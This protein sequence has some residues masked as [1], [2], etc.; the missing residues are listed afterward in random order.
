MTA[1]DVVPTDGLL[2]AGGFQMLHGLVQCGAVPQAPPHALDGAVEAVRNDSG[3]VVDWRLTA[4]A[5]AEQRIAYVQWRS[6][7]MLERVLGGVA[8]V[9]SFLRWAVH[10]LDVSAI[11]ALTLGECTFQPS[12]L[13]R[14]EFQARRANEVL[15]SRGDLGIGI[16]SPQRNGLVRGFAVD[17]APV[18]LL[19]GGGASISAVSQGIEIASD[20]W[21]GVVTRWTNESGQVSAHAGDEPRELRGAAASML[22]KLAPG[23]TEAE[24]KPMPLATIFAPLLV[25]LPELAHVAATDRVPLIVKTR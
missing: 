5:G 1:I 22:V 7:F 21:R 9:R 11:H 2:A 18:L 10:H 23:C 19:A 12:T 24:A 13:S 3:E 14:A 20:G 25:F 17:Q 4:S 15:R 6:S 16:T 8:M